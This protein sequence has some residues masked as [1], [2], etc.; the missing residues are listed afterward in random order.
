MAVAVHGQRNFG[1]PFG[2]TRRKAAGAG[3]VAPQI[4][5]SL[6][7]GCQGSLILSFDRFIEQTNLPDAL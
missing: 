2:L 6:E 7:Q 3:A 1:S 5:L 4:T